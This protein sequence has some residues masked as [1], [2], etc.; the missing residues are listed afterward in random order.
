VIGAF[1]RH[2]EDDRGNGSATRDTRLA[3]IHSLFRYAAPRAPEHAAVIRQVL[4]IPARRPDRAIVS[5]LTPR[6]PTRRLPAPTGPP[7]TGAV[8]T[9]CCC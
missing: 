6:K 3:T 7:G 8:T 9:P 4:A 2:L 5:S 1:V